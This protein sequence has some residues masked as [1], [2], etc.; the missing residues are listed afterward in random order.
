MVPF[1]GVLVVQ[2]PRLLRGGEW[3]ARG[4]ESRNK[5][6][7]RLPVL[8]EE[9]TLRPQQKIEREGWAHHYKGRHPKAPD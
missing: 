7:S 1:R 3:I 8:K 9:F 6:I 4:G 5:V 2:V